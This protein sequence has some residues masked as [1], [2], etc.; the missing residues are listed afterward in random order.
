MFARVFDTGVVSVCITVREFTGFSRL[1]WCGSLLCSC[2]GLI[3]ELSV[4]V[5]A[6]AVRMTNY[7]SR[8]LLCGSLPVSHGCRDAGAC[9]VRAG[10]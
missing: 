6:R 3:R 8:E 2:G 9:C 1:S 5:R 4:F 10:V 7:V